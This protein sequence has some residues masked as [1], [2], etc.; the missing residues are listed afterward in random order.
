LFAVA[1]AYS[2]FD[3]QSIRRREVG[4]PTVQAGPT[5]QTLEDEITQE[6]EQSRKQ[7][8]YSEDGNA[9]ND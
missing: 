1:L 9:D 2:G 3:N 7:T 5:F 8:A 6:D 4:K